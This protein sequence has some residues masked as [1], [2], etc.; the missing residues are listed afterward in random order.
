MTNLLP[1][2]MPLVSIIVP[3]YNRIKY[4]EK[5]LRSAILQSYKNTEII[6]SDNFS[7]TNPEALISILN[8]SR[9]KFYRN[10]ENLGPFR[11]VMNGFS[12][13]TGKYIACLLDDDMWGQDY[14]VK[15]VDVLEKNSNV[16]VAFCDHYVID[17]N[18]NIDYRKTEECSSF[19]GRKFLSDGLYQP[20]HEL[21]V[22]TQA[23]SPAFAAVMVRDAINW[24]AIPSEVDTIW[25]TYLAYLYSSTG[26]AAYYLSDR[27]T[28]SRDHN[29]TITRQS[30]SQ[31]LDLKLSKAESEI[32]CCQIYLTDKKLSFLDSHFQKKLAYHLTT[33]GIATLKKGDQKKARNYFIRALN[34]KFGLR[35][36]GVY[37]LSFLPRIYLFF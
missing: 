19:Y 23:I 36:L 6:V 32:F 9:I 10:N 30:G 25:D 16:V 12:K 26:K 20:F 5:A 15:M 22:L 31:N 13:A 2:E 7:S 11:N 29:Q 18:D 14:L 24:N 1:T 35:T 8:D 4:L 21:A 28:Y 37:I 17:E 27:L 33:A 3:T 34:T